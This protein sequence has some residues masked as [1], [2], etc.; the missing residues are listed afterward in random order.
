M[1]DNIFQWDL[2]NS[3]QRLKSCDR[4]LLFVGDLTEDKIFETSIMSPKTSKRIDSLI[5]LKLFR[6]DLYLRNNYQKL[7]QNV[8]IKVLQISF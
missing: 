7:K 4:M 1:L 5:F 6:F 3:I 2:L 8:I